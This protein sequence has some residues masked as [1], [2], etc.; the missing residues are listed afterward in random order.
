MVSE[1]PGTGLGA[2]CA[3]TLHS[4]PGMRD[5]GVH[6]DR[7][8]PGR[9]AVD[10]ALDRSR[11]RTP[12]A[13]STAAS[14]PAR[15][16]AAGCGWCCARPRR[17]CCSPTSGSSATSPASAPSCSRCR[18]GATRPP[19]EARQALGCCGCA[20][21]STP[22]RGRATAPTLPREL[23]PAAAGGRARRARDH[24]PRHQRGLGRG[25]PQRPHEV[26]HHAGPRH[27]DQ[28][29]DGRGP[30]SRAPARLPARPDVPAAGRGAADGSSTAATRG[31]RRS[32]T[33]CA[34]TASTSTE[35]DV[36][37]RGRRGRRDRA[38]ARR[39]RAGRRRGACATATRRSAT[40]GLGRPA[41]VDPVR[42]RRWSRMIGAGPTAPAA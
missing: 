7:P 31:S 4:D 2:R 42:R 35:D 26:G 8:G 27:G 34:S 14:S 37:R 28:H 19:G 36:R 16:P 25:R 3:G 38:P 1:E 33:G 6:P 20:S 41:Y 23:V 21:T 10:P 5:R 29:P 9:T 12:T 13:P 39:G 30:R 11:R 22:T 18:S 17:C 40:A 24:R 15:R 32:S